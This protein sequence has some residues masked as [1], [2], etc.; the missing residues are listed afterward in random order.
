MITVFCFISEIL[1]PQ[2][3]PQKAPTFRHGYTAFTAQQCE[4]IHPKDRMKRY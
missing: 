1:W 4:V 3:V 2:I